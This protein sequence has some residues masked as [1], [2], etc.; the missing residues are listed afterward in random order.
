[1]SSPPVCRLAQRLPMP[2]TKSDASRVAFP[3][4]C[5]VCRPAIPAISGW[6]S[7]IAPQP[8][9]VG[10]TGVPVSSA[11]SVSRAAAS[12]LITPPP[13]TISG[14]SAAASRSRALPIWARVAAGLYTGSGW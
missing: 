4:R 10:I 8:I 6:S 7:G 12:A 2:S 13:A 1:M 11:N 9:R 14:R 3:Y 5:A